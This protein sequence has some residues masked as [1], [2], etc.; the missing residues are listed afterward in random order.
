[1]I[2]AK[3]SKLD[4]IEHFASLTLAGI[5]QEKYPTIG[6][7]EMLH[8]KEVITKVMSVIVADLS[9]SFGGDL[10]L[11][12]I[13]EVVTEIRSGLCR[14]VTLEGLYMTCSKIKRTSTFKLKVPTILKALD[15]HLEEQTK[16]AAN[17]N[18]NEHLKHK[19]RE[20]RERYDPLANAGFQD[21]QAAYFKSKIQKPTK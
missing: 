18:Y 10:K 21:F 19:H 5:L 2:S 20:P 17:A 9:A 13:Q 4:L 6:R 1:M 14:N 11:E 12:E 3:A 16:A 7:L 8:G 15:E